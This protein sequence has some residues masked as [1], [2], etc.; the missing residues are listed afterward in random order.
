VFDNGSC[1]EVVQYLVDE[2]NKGNI[3]YLLLSSKNLGKGGAWNQIFG[4]APGEIVSYADNDIYFHEGWLEQSLTILE[5]YPNVGM[6]TARPIRTEP[7]YYSNTLAWARSTKGVELLDGSFL[8]WESFYHYNVSLGKTESLEE[9]YQNGSDWKLR[10]Q[11]VETLVGASHWQFTAQTSVLRKFLPFNMDRPMGQ[12]IHL[13]Q[14]INQEGYLRLMTLASYAVNLSN[15]LQFTPEVPKIQVSNGGNRIQDGK[16]K[17]LHSFLD[18]A[19]VKKVLLKV[20]D[21]LFD[22]YFRRDAPL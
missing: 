12:V 21:K 17:R 15:S 22:W 9:Q 4:M 6:V 11:E 14:R 8:P 1:E 19:P 10:Y 18:F 3:Q 16:Q 2:R 5:T 7:D 13:D 20:Y